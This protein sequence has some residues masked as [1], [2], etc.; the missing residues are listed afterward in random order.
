MFT[1]F[2]EEAMD[3]INQLL[4]AV[5]ASASPGTIDYVKSQTEICSKEAKSAF[6]ATLRI[7]CKSMNLEQKSASRCYEPYIQDKLRDVGYRPALNE[8][9]EY[10]VW[11][12][13]H[14][15][16]IWFL[17]ILQGRAA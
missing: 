2:H 15:V 8:K 11:L 17:H 1:D 3:I 9:G 14:L 6:D 5:E 7:V 12:W 4:Q 10:Y 13:L 16:A